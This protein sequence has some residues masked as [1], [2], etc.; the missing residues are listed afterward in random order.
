MVRV[1]AQTLR[2]SIGV[3]S[4]VN[5]SVRTWIDPNPEIIMVPWMAW[6]TTHR[7]TMNSDDRA[8]C[9]ELHV[10]PFTL[11]RGCVYISAAGSWTSSW[12][13]VRDLIDT[14]YTVHAH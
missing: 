11:F 4:G 9:G 5:L 14:K 6:P 1:E 12:P 2:D 3:V 8:V 7:M 13:A 10:T